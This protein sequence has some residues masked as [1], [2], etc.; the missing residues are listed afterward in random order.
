MAEGILK[1]LILDEVSSRRV[2]L[3]IDVLSAGIRAEDGLAA[4][5]HAVQTAAA[6]GISLQFHRSR[7]LT[8]AIAR[9]AD[10]ILVM[11]RTH[12]DYIRYHWA[13]VE[14]VYELRRFGREGEFGPEE[15]EI[16]DPMGLG[17]EAY[18]RTFRVLR[19]E[20]TRVSRILFPLVR[21]KYTVS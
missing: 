19:E 20:I 18:L 15:T 4:S 17:P 12:A 5:R 7:Q 11:E 13:D 14:R 16:P 10:L 21:E 2:P 9:S 8:A 3:P 6:H 1:D